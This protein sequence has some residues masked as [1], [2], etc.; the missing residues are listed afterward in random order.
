MMAHSLLE[1]LRA[2]GR[3]ILVAVTRNSGGLPTAW[4][5]DRWAQTLLFASKELGYEIVYVGT[6]QDA[7]A[8][9]ALMEMAGGMGSS[10]AGKTSINQLAAL[11]A[12]SDMVITLNTGTMHVTRAVGTPALVLDIAWEKPLEW[13]PFNRPEVRMLRGPDLE[14]IPPN[15]RMDEI[16]VEWACS[17]L[18]SMSRQF[19]PDDVAREGR[20][21]ASLSEIDHLRA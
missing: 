6:A 19:P 11:I 18:A 9:A 13:M 5:D 3:P 21:K 8:I 2:A 10:L 7:P 4:H 14:T 1:P 17:E 16:S 20:L 12:L 15:Y